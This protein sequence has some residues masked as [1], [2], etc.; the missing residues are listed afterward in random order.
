MFG[1]FGLRGLSKLRLGWAFGQL[2]YAQ[3]PRAYGPQQVGGPWLPSAFKGAQQN[4]SYLNPTEQNNG[5]EN[6][7]HLTLPVIV[8]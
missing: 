8:D 2:G 3:E 6:I 7:D 1:P 5:Q 4:I